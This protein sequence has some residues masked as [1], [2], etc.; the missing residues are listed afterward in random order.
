MARSVGRAIAGRRHLVVQAGTGTGKSLAYLIPAMLAGERVVV[1]TATKALQDQL[2]G[3]DLPSVATLATGEFSFAVLKGRSNYL[4]KQRAAEVGGTG[5]QLTMEGASAETPRP[6]PGRTEDNGRLGDQVRRLLD[7]GQDSTTGDRAELDF[8]PAPK[9]WAMV[10][11]TARECPGAYR[12]PSGHDCFAEDARSRAAEA[13]VVVVNTHLYG[14]HLASGGVVLPPHDVVVFDEAH[15]VEEVMTD[16]LGT[17][18]GPGRFRAL[19][20]SARGLV[21][22]RADSAVEAVA[23]IGDVLQRVL[24]PL[25]G[26][27][28]ARSLLIGSA[29]TGEVSAADTT[30]VSAADTGKVSA[31]ERSQPAGPEGVGTDPEPQGLD[32]GLP[33]LDPGT[34]RTPSG[35]RR[36]RT[37]AAVSE[38]TVPHVASSSAAAAAGA[39]TGRFGVRAAAPSD[40]GLGDLVDL[41]IGRVSRL[42]DGLRRAE[43]ETGESDGSEIRSRRDRALLAAGHLSDDLAKL[44][45][46]TDDQVAWVDGGSRFPTLR[47]SPIEVGPL[48]ADRLWDEV[49]GV[50]TSATV[51]V[52]LRERLGLPADRTD[53]LDVGS[54]FDYPSHAVLYVARSLPDRRRPESEPAIHDELAA[55]MTAAGGRTL[56]LFTSWR[57]MTAA[58][59]ALRDRVEFPILAQSDLPKPALIE[60]FRSDEATCLFAT[61]GFWQ[62]VDIPGSTLSVVA[63][64]RIPFP[65]P[66]DPVLQARRD[67]AGAAAFQ[68]VDLPRAGTLLAQGAGRLIRS[69]DDRGV[70]A[71]LDNRL[72]TASYRGVLLARVPPMHRVVERR[73]VEEFLQ[74]QVVASS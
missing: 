38:A 46:L 28:V 60:A 42:V 73:L 15:E 16:S 59:A 8:E 61:L 53:E 23:E 74:H 34:D 26:S 14:A 40:P 68:T 72:A 71:V 70:V 27:R 10:S 12:C 35:K 43:R 62:G 57:A 18:I 36:S 49:T 30:E 67:R 52:G 64:D 29:P 5:E 48:L 65:R 22:D 69:A 54:P 6:A 9:A 51:P 45:V 24:Q 31:A 19:A 2:A 56:A 44:A 17:E 33:P 47:I 3:K 1:A 58:V 25:A 13:D 41:A 55:L 66:D 50:L 39:G 32:L 7:W 37:V 20:A 63:I 11:T 21:D 4:C